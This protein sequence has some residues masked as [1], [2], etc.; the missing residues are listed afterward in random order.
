MTKKARHQ[1]APHQCAPMN[2][3]LH[4]LSGLG[5]IDYLDRL[6]PTKQVPGK[7]L[8]YRNRDAIIALFAMFLFGLRRFSQT[9]AVK[10]TSYWSNFYLS[11]ISY[12]SVKAKILSLCQP[13]R[14]VKKMS[15]KEYRIYTLHT[16]PTLNDAIFKLSYELGF[17]RSEKPIVLDVDS[18]LL[19]SKGK[20][21]S[22]NRYGKQGQHPLVLIT[23]RVSVGYVG[24]SGRASAKTDIAETIAEFWERMK[25]VNCSIS[26]IRI[27]SAGYV[28]ETVRKI[29]NLGL[30]FL[31]SV[32]DPKDLSNFNTVTRTVDGRLMQFAEEKLH[33]GPTYVRYIYTND[34]TKKRTFAIVT[35]DFISP[36]ESLVQ[37]YRQRGT[38]EQVMRDLRDFGWQTMAFHKMKPNAAYMG[39]CI[40]SLLLFRFITTSYSRTLSG[41]APVDFINPYCTLETFHRKFMSCVGTWDGEHL[42]TLGD[43]RQYIYD[44]LLSMN[45]NNKQAA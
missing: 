43:Y 4:T 45:S 6:L 5:I 40:I 36:P 34:Y 9:T 30:K 24:R 11:E 10:N 29:D 20:G 8:K 39:C 44:Y 25:S 31:I 1:S 16:Q 35:N 37:L 27:D 7:Y 18:I 21:T 13:P 38:S 42:N 41:I 17:I 15:N 14:T 22:T 19:N 23:E 12:Q 28:K 32:P 26:I 3:I 33:F 2:V